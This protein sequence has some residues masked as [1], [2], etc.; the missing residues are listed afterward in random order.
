MTK[1]NNI[2]LT[3]LNNFLNSLYNI[4]VNILRNYFKVVLFIF[5]ILFSQC[6][7][8]LIYSRTKTELVSGQKVVPN[9]NKFKT[10]VSRENPKLGDI[11]YTLKMDSQINSFAFSP[12]GRLFASGDSLGNVFIWDITNGNF[13]TSLTLDSSIEK[14]IFSSNMKYLVISSSSSLNVFFIENWT[15]IT[16]IKIL[17]LNLNIIFT[18]SSNSSGFF[19]LYP[20]IKSCG[21]NCQV[22]DKFQVMFYNFSSKLTSKL[23]NIDSS[24]IDIDYNNLN[25]EFIFLLSSSTIDYYNSDFNSLSYSKSFSSFMIGPTTRFINHFLIIKNSNELKIYDVYN[26]KDIANISDYDYKILTVSSDAKKIISWNDV[27]KQYS[28]LNL[29]DKI[30]QI[31]NLTLQNFNDP[32][33]ILFSPDNSLLVLGDLDGSIK[34]L[35]MIGSPSLEPITQQSKVNPDLMQIKYPNNE[36]VYYDINNYSIIVKDF[37]SNNTIKSFTNPCDPSKVT[38]TWCEFVLSPD[39]QKVLIK[40]ENRSFDDKLWIY[41]RNIT[42]YLMD[43]QTSSMIKLESFTTDEFPQLDQYMSFPMKFSYEGTYFAIIIPDNFVKIYSSYSGKKVDDFPVNCQTWSYDREKSLTITNVAFTFSKE[44][45]FAISCENKLEIWNID[46]GSLL[47]LTNNLNLN[48]NPILSILHDKISFENILEFSPDGESLVLFENIEIVQEFNGAIVQD[49]SISAFIWNLSEGSLK[50]ISFGN[51]GQNN[52]DFITFIPNSDYFIATYQSRKSSTIEFWSLTYGS[53][54][55]EKNLGGYLIS[56]IYVNGKELIA[57]LQYDVGFFNPDLIFQIYQFDLFRDN[58]LTFLDFDNDGMFD[59]WE[60]HYSLDFNN[61]WDRFE[62][63][64]QDGLMNIIEF[65]YQSNPLNNDTNGNGK[66]DYEEIFGN[67]YSLVTPS[68]NKVLSNIAPTVVNTN[69]NYNSDYQL[70]LLLII[71]LFINFLTVLVISSVIYTRNKNKKKY[72]TETLFLSDKLVT[73]EKIRLLRALY[74]KTLIGIEQVQKILYQNNSKQEIENKIAL[75]MAKNTI[76]TNLYPEDIQIEMKSQLKGRTILILV[77]LAF[78]G[79]MKSNTKLISNT[80]QIPQ[81][82]VTKELK[83]LLELKYIKSFVNTNVLEDNRFKYFTVTEKGLI[84]L[85]LLKETL[86]LT[87]LQL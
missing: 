64:D 30:Q 72:K 28:I 74:H 81:P 69:F 58:Q 42:Y 33:I 82:T 1:M 15:L 27:G 49:Q 48:K 20:N 25:D 53:L 41:K 31:L 7:F 50:S 19:F 77:E 10:S 26:K 71:L 9:P 62:D 11:I 60:Q 39:L 16:N 79:P 84:F 55:S 59:V 37:H 18:L 38:N 66:S 12:D 5:L 57:V 46:T 54:L 76:I 63:P 61:Y 80:L 44:N 75:E 34:I 78:Q 32:Q 65:Y 3:F 85:H 22:I 2:N 36:L 87:L 51:T 83:R 45:N 14:I 4:N 73:F 70:S 17:N 86:S 43:I 6:L 29:Q 13:L 24:A 56:Q 47:N 68:L 8:P 23:F 40:Y 21:G 35:N 52:I 67:N